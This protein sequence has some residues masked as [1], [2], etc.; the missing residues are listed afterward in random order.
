[1]RAADSSGGKLSR[2]RGFSKLL[3]ELSRTLRRRANCKRLR[4]ACMPRNRRIKRVVIAA[5]SGGYQVTADI[6]S[7]RR[8]KN[9]GFEVS[10]IYLFD[11]LYGGLK[12]FEGWLHAKRSHK[13]ISFYVGGRPA[14]NNKRLRKRLKK[15]GIRT[16]H[17]HKDRRLS[18]RE[19]TRGRAIFI[20]TPDGHSKSTYLHNQLRDC[21]YASLLRRRGKTRWFRN[22]SKPRSLDSRR[23]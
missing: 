16:L 1:M 4:G 10:E 8:G 20:H 5:H 21:L 9:G 6:V 2:P 7:G 14:A 17:E 23:R 18:R 15:H 22:K 13:L 12:S 3:S 19:L 11:A